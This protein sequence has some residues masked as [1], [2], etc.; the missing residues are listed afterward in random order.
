[1]ANTTDFLSLILPANNEFNDT[2][3]VPM[4]ANFT[5][6][7]QEIETISNEIQS[8][9]FTL[10]DLATFLAVSHNTDGTLIASDEQDE[11]RNSPIYGDDESGTDYELKD[12]L[13]K[14]DREIY[15]ARE[16]EASLIEA[17]ALRGRLLTDPDTVLDGAK[18]GSGNPNFMSTSGTDFQID[19]TPTAIRFNIDGYLMEMAYD[20]SVTASGGAGTKYLV[21]QRPGTPY[22]S[23]DNSTGGI[24]QTTANTLNNNKTQVFKD[25][26]E[27][28]TLLDVRAGD[29]LEVV[30]TDNAGEYVIVTVGFNGNNDE[31]LIKGIF[32]SVV[33]SIN[34]KLKDTLRPSFS[35]ETAYTPAAGK[36][37]VGEAYWDTASL[38]LDITYA[39]KGE[40]ES[41][42]IAIDVSVTPTFEQTINHNLGFI[43][44][45]V[46]VYATQLADGVEPWEPLGTSAVGDTLS[47]TPSDTFNYVQGTFAP[48]TGDATHAADSFSGAVTTTLTG[49][50]H[51]LKSV[52]VK[53]EPKTV[54]V[55]NVRA[56]HFYRDYDGSDPQTGFL[57]VIVKR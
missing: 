46:R 42:Y 24:G 6:V 9:R 28:F 34:Y 54:T 1:M 40:F 49:T 43:P 45:D 30:N 10:T 56:N 26:G 33:G 20:E 11:A 25:T 41:I 19:G 27:N 53:I 50:I 5:K 35:I 29:I 14:G 39:F 12:R 52:Q 4:N 18:D 31:L 44:R 7:D 57:K 36:C 37:I 16:N 15:D 22:V 32:K 51:D 48:G 13:D 47:L 23:L 2:W 8:A 21:A 38:T 55:K 17:H 3:D